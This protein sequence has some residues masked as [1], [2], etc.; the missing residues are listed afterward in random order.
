[1]I[2]VKNVQDIIGINLRHY[3]S[4]VFRRFFILDNNSNDQTASIILCFKR[5]YKKA[6]VFMV[7]IFDKLIFNKLK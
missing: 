5:D 2:L 1:M 6:E 3:Y 4:L 7:L